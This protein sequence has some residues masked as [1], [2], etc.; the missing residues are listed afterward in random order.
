MNPR[1]AAALALL[2]LYLFLPISA[3]GLRPVC[4]QQ[5]ELRADLEAGTLKTWRAIYGSFLRYRSCDEG[6]IA[7]GYSDSVVRMLAERWDELSSLQTLVDHDDGFRRF[8]FSHIDATTSPED[9]E[10]V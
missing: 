10:T 5:D 9:L 3:Q 7:E 4:D 6:T 2:S 1:H 8:V